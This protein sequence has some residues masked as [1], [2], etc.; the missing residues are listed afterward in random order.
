MLGHRILL[1]VALLI[2]ARRLTSSQEYSDGGKVGG[3][4]DGG[5]M[6]G[7]SGVSM[8]RHNHNQK[9]QKHHMNAQQSVGSSTGYHQE[10]AIPLLSVTIN[11]DPKRYLLRMLKSI[12]YPIDLIQIT[13]GNQN[14]TLVDRIVKDIKRGEMIVRK[15]F[16]RT[17]VKIKL[18]KINPGAAYGFNEALQYLD[19]NTTEEDTKK[20]SYHHHFQHE[21]SGSGTSEKR[22]FFR[23]NRKQAHAYSVPQWAL[24]VN[25]DIAF[26]PNV[27]GRIAWD[28]EYLLDTDPQFGIGFTSLCCGSEWSAV[29]FT[30]RALNK[31]GFAD[32]NFYPAYYEDEDYGIRVHLSGLKAA[33]FNN[34]ALL[35]GEIDGSKDYL[36]GTFD[37]LYLHPKQDAEALNWRAT[38]QR[39]VQYGKQYIEKKW[40]VSVGYMDARGTFHAGRKKLDCKS[41]DGI[42]KHCGAALGFKVP[43]NDP[44]NSIHHWKLD[45]DGRNGILNR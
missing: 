3:G 34:T 15:K 7:M 24:V 38:H 4:K 37:Q 39:G 23:L 36:S 12:D 41:L 25:G 28:T 9:H 32:E 44:G 21:I 27:L 2:F 10:Q 42:N 20:P 45:Q 22:N 5:V 11:N 35:H 33:R 26:Y 16:R 1:L 8:K 6:A 31:V 18:L 40:G 29:V 14:A 43:F 17:H 30:K 19:S 13:I